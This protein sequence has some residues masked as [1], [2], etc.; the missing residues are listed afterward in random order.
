MNMNVL[1]NMIVRQLM[2]RAVNFGIGAG[3]NAASKRGKAG[4]SDGQSNTRPVVGHDTKQA[5]KK[6][7]LVRRGPWR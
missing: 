1:I 4:K 7:G 3:I 2:R 6:M 5:L